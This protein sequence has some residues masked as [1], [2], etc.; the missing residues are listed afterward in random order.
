MPD[1][2]S[3]LRD[4]IRR[5]TRKEIRTSVD[6]LK[7]QVVALTRRLREAERA[8]VRLQRSTQRAIDAVAGQTGAIV[9]E[10]DSQEG[11][12]QIRVSAASVLKHR[13]RL[14]LTQREMA[15]LVG[16]ATGTVV[17]WEQ[18]QNSPRGASR[19]AFARLRQMGVREAQDRL[20]KMG[21]R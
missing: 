6:P 11:G 18:G 14:G 15:E 9:P 7:K 19:E 4:E 2:A 20:E 3:V 17:R 1:V 8:I 13:E 21:E 16:V 5:L 12:R 10:P